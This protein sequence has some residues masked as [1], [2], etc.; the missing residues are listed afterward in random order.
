LTLRMPTFVSSFVV[1]IFSIPAARA[2][3]IW[4]RLSAVAIPRRRHGR[5]TAVSLFSASGDSA[6]F[7][8]SAV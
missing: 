4:A 3:S 2:A 7:R 1:E 5:L 8:R 6:P